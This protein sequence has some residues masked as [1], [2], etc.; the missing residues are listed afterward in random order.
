MSVTLP[1]NSSG[2]QVRTVTSGGFDTFCSVLSD[3][4]NPANL[5]SINTPN[6]G[7]VAR[8]N[9]LAV[10]SA[11]VDGGKATY[12]ASVTGLLPTAAATTDL[13]VLAGSSTKVVKVTQV[14]V[15]GTI[16]TTAVYADFRLIK[17]STA[18]SSGT[19][20]GQTAVP[21]DSANSAATAVFTTFVSTGPT[22]GA[23]VGVVAAVKYFLGVTGTPVL[24]TSPAILYQAGS[25]GAQAITLRG[26][27]QAVAI[28]ANAVTFGTAPN[29]SFDIEWTEE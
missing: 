27:A 21:L 19:A 3:G 15:S 28:D 16:A 13:A 20:T 11:L 6:S 1:P 10:S 8:I 23:L 7:V 17:R 14:R 9:E 29:L 24:D 12:R 22:V 2:T 5:G 18:F 25:P 26:V 4:V